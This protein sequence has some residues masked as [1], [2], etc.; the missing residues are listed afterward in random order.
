MAALARLSPSGPAIVAPYVAVYA[1]APQNWPALRSLFRSNL[2]LAEPTLAALA[3]NEATAPAVLALADPADKAGNAQWLEPL[4]ATLTGGGRY[5]EARAIW[6]RTTRSRLNGLV[7]DPA[8]SDKVS[9]PPFNWALTSST[10]G[11]AERQANGRL[12][13]I[14]YGQEDGLLA[15]QMLLLQPGGYRLSMRVIGDQAR[16]RALNWSIW[17][18]KADA[19]IASVRL[20]TIAAQGLAFRVPAGCA[21]QWLKLSAVS[22]DVPQQV[23][24]T[25][26]ALK[27]E[28]FAGA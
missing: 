3:R 15:T 21:A 7:Y 24:V 11:L 13:V 18:D 8:F 12:H 16:A 5:G 23:D 14:F 22:T 26:E 20:D 10:V 28:K 17:C 4:L 9:P 19:P 6:E 25:I 2:D 1:R 27:L